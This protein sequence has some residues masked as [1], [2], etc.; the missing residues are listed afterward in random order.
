MIPSGAWRLEV[1]MARI[2]FNYRIN[3]GKKAE[4]SKGGYDIRLLF[5]TEDGQETEQGADLKVKK[6]PHL[7][8][9]PLILSAVQIRTLHV[10]LRITRHEQPE[11][12]C[13]TV[14]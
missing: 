2:V 1:D 8:S 7:G 4:T 6:L 10:R 13:F 11:S 9:F 5:R 12:G 3:K 14:Y